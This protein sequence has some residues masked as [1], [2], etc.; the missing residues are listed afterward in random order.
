[1]TNP[2]P[3]SSSAA[4]QDF[5]LKEAGPGSLVVAPHQRLAQQLWQRQRQA[6]LQ[7]GR[8]AWEPLPIKTLQGFLQDS[9]NALWP[10]VALAPGL[11][12]L[13]LWLRAIAAT[14][15]IPGTAADLSWAQ[16]L[17]ETYNILCRHSLLAGGGATPHGRFPPDGLAASGY[18]DF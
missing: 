15:A 1:M 17:D 13:S 14:P 11:R 4:L 6:E 9:F 12:R 3:F 10:E 2:P 16:A 7:A 8:A 5:I 18:P